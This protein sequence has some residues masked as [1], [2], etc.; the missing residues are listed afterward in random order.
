MPRGSVSSLYYHAI[1]CGRSGFPG[2]LF[3]N[4]QKEEFYAAPGSH[5]R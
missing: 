3:F 1:K 4:F 5:T 2:G